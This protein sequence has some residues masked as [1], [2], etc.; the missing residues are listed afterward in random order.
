MM[1]VCIPLSRV[2]LKGITS[3][4]SFATLIGMDVGIDAMLHPALSPLSSIENQLGDAPHKPKR[5]RPHSISSIKPP[6]LPFSRTASRKSQLS[7][8]QAGD[9]DAAESFD[10]S[11]SYSA[12]QDNLKEQ[13]SLAFNIAVLNEQVWFAEA[14]QSAVNASKLRKYAETAKEPKIVLEVDGHDCL[15]ADDELELKSLGSPGSNESEEDEDS[16]DGLLQQTRK[17]E[18]AFMAAKVFGLKE[19]EGI[20]SEYQATVRAKLIQQ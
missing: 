9:A 14:L 12:S 3:Y 16:G 15:A 11:N 18:K 5:I 17:R 6:A 1:R 8:L 20:W 19:E 7:S 10:T 13:K 4:Q 2:T